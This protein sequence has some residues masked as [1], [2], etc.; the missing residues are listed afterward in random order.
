M[1]WLIAGGSGQLGRAL[2]VELNSRG[3]DFIALNSTEF[4]VTKNLQVNRKIESIVPNVIINCAAWTNVDEAELNESASYLVNTLGPKNLAAAANKVGAILIQIST[5]YVFS[6]EK[7]S[8][9]TE[10]DDYSPKS[11]YGATKCEGEK[12]VI[13]THP[14]KTYIVRTAWLYSMYGN[15]FAKAM[16]K[17][18]LK[19]D[20]EVRV[21]N[22]QV[23]QPTFTGDLTNQLL[24]LVLLE[25]PVGIYHGTNSGQATW[26]EFAQEIF[27]LIGADVTRVIPVA[28]SE[29]AQL[30]ER[31]KY[32]V[33]DHAGWSKTRIPA[34][35]DWRIAL[36]EALP[37]IVSAT[38]EE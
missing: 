29:F 22:D 36:T 10:T 3:I 27:K 5:D 28:S 18:A 24:D 26:F 16:V 32:S 1:T 6:G 20:G 33:L 21:V 13:R 34:M 31:P 15:N 23:G 11:V 35:R 19:K 38:K 9:W 30:A 7:T 37:A 14:D 17:L 8:P 4:D 25:S 12:F 2:Q